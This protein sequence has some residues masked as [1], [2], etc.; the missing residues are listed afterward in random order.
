MNINIY[1]KYHIEKTV[2]YCYE[3]EEGDWLTKREIKNVVLNGIDF[4]Y[5]IEKSLQDIWLSNFIM[6]DNEISIESFNP[7]NGKTNLTKW[8]VI[9]QENSVDLNEL[10]NEDF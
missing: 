4:L 7:E 9:D 2:E 6:K 5:E 3:D 10:Y 1:T 8:K